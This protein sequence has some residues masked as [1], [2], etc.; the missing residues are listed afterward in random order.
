[1]S[2]DNVERNDFAED[3]ELIER[4]VP[5]VDNPSATPIRGVFVGKGSS[6]ETLRVYTTV[7]L[8]RYLEV[9]R[10]KVL[11]IKRFPSGAIVVWVPGDLRLAVVQTDVLM[12]DLLRGGIQA[13]SRGLGGLRSLLARGP[14]GGGGEVTRSPFCQTN[15]VD[16]SDPTCTLGCPPPQTGCGCG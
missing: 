11:G 3:E 8:N 2:S 5:E 10:D 14:I 12:A 6:D 16:P 7:E 15:V 4:L 9:P 1:M 13:Q